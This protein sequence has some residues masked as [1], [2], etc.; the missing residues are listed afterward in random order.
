[1]LSGFTLDAVDLLGISRR[2]FVGAGQSGDVSADVTRIRENIK[3][4]FQ[5]AEVRVRRIGDDG[6]SAGMKVDFTEMTVTANGQSP[7]ASLVGAA[8]L[9][10]Y[11]RPPDF[12]ALVTPAP[13]LN[14][15]PMGKPIS[16]TRSATSTGVRCR[17]NALSPSAAHEWWSRGHRL[18]CVAVGDWV[19]FGVSEG[20]PPAGAL[21]QRPGPWA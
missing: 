2:I 10:G 18:R 13:D 6:P 20:G 7:L 15:V 5:V 8:G 11:R 19:G 14:Q 17:S 12:S 3:D 21:G 4:S 1:M 16:S 9:L